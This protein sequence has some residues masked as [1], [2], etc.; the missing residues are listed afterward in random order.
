MDTTTESAGTGTPHRSDVPAPVPK[1]QVV[2]PP[3]EEWHG[4]GGAGLHAQAQQAMMAEMT[5]HYTAD[6]YKPKALAKGALDL[7][8]KKY[9][10]C[11][12]SRQIWIA[13]RAPG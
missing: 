11:C 8:T 13:C 1:P 9:E 4:L 2:K 5:G 10:W 7:L 12:V 3:M 6:D